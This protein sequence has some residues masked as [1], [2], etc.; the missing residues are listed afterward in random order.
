M[1]SPF[2]RNQRT[3]SGLCLHHPDGMNPGRGGSTMSFHR[4]RKCPGPQKPSPPLPL[5]E[6]FLF[7]DADAPSAERVDA[8]PAP[9]NIEQRDVTD[10]DWKHRIDDEKVTHRLEAEHRPEQ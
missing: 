8:T 2:A 5:S 7:S 9:G 6:A 1:R 10:P 3:G 4:L